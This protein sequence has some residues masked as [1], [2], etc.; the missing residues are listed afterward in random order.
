LPDIKHLPQWQLKLQKLIINDIEG[1]ERQLTC[2]SCIN[3]VPKQ[4]MFLVETT[5]STL[6]PTFSTHQIKLLL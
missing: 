5:E 2:V 4:N 1:T 6:I 3:D